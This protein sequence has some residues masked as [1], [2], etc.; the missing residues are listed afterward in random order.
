MK[1]IYSVILL[2][3]VMLSSCTKDETDI[4]TDDNSNAPALAKTRSDGSDMVEYELLPNPYTVDVIQGVYDSYN[5]SKTIE[6]TDLYVRFLPQ[7]SLQLIALKNDY[8][9]ELFDY[10][11]NIELPE[12]AVYQDPTIPEGSFTWLYTTV[13]PDFA[14]PKEIP[15]EVIEECYIPA[16]DETAVNG[17]WV[18][19]PG[20]DFFEAMKKQLG[21]KKVIAENL[22]FLTDSVHKLLDDTGFPGMN[23]LEFAFGAYDDSIYL[24]HKYKENSVV[25]TG[26]HDNDTVVGW[27]ETLSEDDKKFLE[28]YLKYSTIERTGTVHLDLISLALESRSDMVIIPLQDYLGLGN[29]ARINTPSTVGGNWEWRVKEE[30]L[31]D[32]LKE[33]IRTLTIKYRTVAE[34]NAKKAAEEAQQ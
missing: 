32:E 26:T 24:P 6:P 34:E 2:L 14:F 22:G 25:Y 15:Y 23:I 8:D 10:P 18:K 30:Q 29:E 11:L 9:L 27:Y 12:D 33:L 20:M 17:E 13:K 31:T 1:K 16:E 19:G 5:V 7:D 21:D 28:H 4:M 3:A